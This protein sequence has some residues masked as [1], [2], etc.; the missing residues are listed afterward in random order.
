MDPDDFISGAERDT[1][2]ERD[3]SA[4]VMYAAMGVTVGPGGYPDSLD[5]R[6][7]LPSVRD[8]GSRG[9]CVAQTGAAIKEYQER[10][11][12]G[13]EGHFSPEYI[14]FYRENKPGVG[15]QPRDL[16]QILATRGCCTESTLKYQS[17]EATATV[18]I[19]KNVDNKAANYKIA[20]YARIY[21]IDELKT[22][23][24]QSGVCYI[25]FPVYDFRPEF[26]RK[27]TPESVL[28]GGHAVAVVG[29]NIKGFIL[30]NSWGEDYGDNGHIIYPYTDF[31]Q[32]W[33]IWTAIDSE[34]SP[35]PPPE[36]NKMCCT[37][38]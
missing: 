7:F 36:K 6:K 10:M 25:S 35:K 11:D 3:Y 20:E 26:W 19:P 12:V 17:T 15:M 30:R 22:A 23:L 31:G 16:M 33:D 13:Y 37:T 18:E 9:T 21:T 27:K 4:G 34:G 8:Q 24:F 32:H 38:M 29:Y 5:L 28:K 14:Y 2:D 1:F